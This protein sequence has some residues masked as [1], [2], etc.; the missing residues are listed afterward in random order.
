MLKPTYNHKHADTI[1]GLQDNVCNENTTS[2]CRHCPSGSPD[3]CF[4][5]EDL[6]RNLRSITIVPSTRELTLQRCQYYRHWQKSVGQDFYPM[7]NDAQNVRTHRS[8]HEEQLRQNHF[9]ESTESH[10][11]SSLLSI[12]ATRNTSA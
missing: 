2:N 3:L 12:T 11:P 6:L 4:H 10:P 5:S 9:T 7:L 1:E 8:G